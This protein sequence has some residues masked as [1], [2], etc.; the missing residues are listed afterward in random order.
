MIADNGKNDAASSRYVYLGS[1]EDSE[2]E[3]LG[4]YNF[5]ERTYFEDTGEKKTASTV[6]NPAENR[7]CTTEYDN[8]NNEQQNH[9]ILYRKKNLIS[10]ESLTELMSKIVNVF[11]DETTQREI[12]KSEGQLNTDAPDY[13]WMKKVLEEDGMVDVFRHF[14]PRADSR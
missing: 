7:A 11:W 9:A 6:V 10:I 1:Y 8:F 4:C 3:A 12:A 13:L 14:Y 5:D 2:E